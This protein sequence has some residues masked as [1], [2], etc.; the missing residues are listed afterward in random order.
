MLLK[1]L[2]KYQTQQRVS[3]FVVDNSKP[4]KFFDGASQGNPRARGASGTPHVSDQQQY[5]FFCDLGIC[6]NNTPKLR[7]TTVLLNL[8]REMKIV[9][10]QGY[11]DSQLVIYWL[12]GSIEHWNIQLNVVV[13]T[14]TKL[15]ATF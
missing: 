2:K 12:H 14:I 9:K 15:M 6:T 7:S 10:L 8:A 3:P 4:Y 11:K 1:E 5:T 13:G